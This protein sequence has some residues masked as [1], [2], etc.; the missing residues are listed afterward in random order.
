MVVPV[1]SCSNSDVSVVV[2]SAIHMCVCVVVHAH[3]C[4]IASS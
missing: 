2:H 3:A 4:S 1:L